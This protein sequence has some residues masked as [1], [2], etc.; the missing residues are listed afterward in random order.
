MSLL[1]LHSANWWGVKLK[2]L[3]GFKSLNLKKPFE[4]TDLGWKAHV[5]WLSQNFKHF[6]RDAKFCVNW[7]IM[8]SLNTRIVHFSQS[9]VSNFL[10]IYFSFLPRK[11]A[12]QSCLHRNNVANTLT[13]VLEASVLFS[14]NM[15]RL[16]KQS[17]G[18]TSIEGSITERLAVIT[19]VATV[20]YCYISLATLPPNTFQ[21]HYTRW[22]RS[23]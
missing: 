19:E 5:N 14:T 10:C 11:D 2:N 21:S 3:E 12:M 1:S 15:P 13:I 4:S 6:L 16:K 7:F 23:W 9:S 8:P 22:L 20:F 18:K 17:A